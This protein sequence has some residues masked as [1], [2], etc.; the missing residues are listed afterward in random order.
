MNEKQIDNEK[1]LIA[2]DKKL[3]ENIAYC[4]LESRCYFGDVIDYSLRFSLNNYINNRNEKYAKMTPEEIV[5][6]YGDDM[7]LDTASTIIELAKQDKLA[8]VK[9]VLLNRDTDGEPLTVVSTP[10]II[11]LCESCQRMA[12]NCK[13][14]Y[15]EENVPFIEDDVEEYD[16]PAPSRKIN[17]NETVMPSLQQIIESAH[18][19]NIQVNVVMD[20]K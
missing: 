5:E 10:N 13:A 8:I 6:I 9:P 15:E 16:V 14:N 18:H 4:C 12:E 17:P 20:D 7:D 1:I 2:V 11:G 3:C 19:V